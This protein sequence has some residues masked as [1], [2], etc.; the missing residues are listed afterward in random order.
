MASEV[1]AGKVW[2][3]TRLLLATPGVEIHTLRIQ[4]RSHCSLHR[5]QGKWNAFIGV[6]G[7]VL[8]E[9]HQPDT[10]LVDVTE[11]T[12]G[13]LTTVAPG[14]WHRFRTEDDYAECLEIYYP[15]ALGAPDIER[16]DAGG[17][18]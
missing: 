9:V 17:K 16:R 5:H 1:I 14:L 7:R 6:L 4:P 10:G 13:A 3:E 12:P 2:G 8:V 11:V 18:D 15:A